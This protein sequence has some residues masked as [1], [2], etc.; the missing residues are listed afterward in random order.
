LICGCRWRWGSPA[1]D[2]WCATVTASASSY[3][4]ATSGMQ[5]VRQRPRLRT[6]DHHLDEPH[7][8]PVAPQLPPRPPG[9]RGTAGH[10]PLVG[11]TGQRRQL[12]HPPLG[13]V[14]VIRPTPVG[15]HILPGSRRRAGVDLHPAVHSQRHPINATRQ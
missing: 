9:A 1:R 14:V 5:R 4:V 8:L 15:L 11:V 7:R 2:V 10:P 3:S 13:E 12:G 6:V